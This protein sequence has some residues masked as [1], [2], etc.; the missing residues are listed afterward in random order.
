VLQ[1]AGVPGARRLNPTPD[2]TWG[3]HLV[4]AN[5]GLGNLVD[6]VH[7]EAAAYAAS[8]H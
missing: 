2:A 8:G 5:I 7:S 3:L 6:L 4:D 1:V